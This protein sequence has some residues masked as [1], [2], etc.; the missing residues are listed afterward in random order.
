MEEQLM[1]WHFNCQAERSP[2]DEPHVNL[3]V[4]V[5]KAK[6][7]RGLE[8]FW[9]KEYTAWTCSTRGKL[10]FPPRPW[11]CDCQQAFFAAEA[12]AGEGKVVLQLRDRDCVITAFD[13]LLGRRF[14][15]AVLAMVAT[16]NAEKSSAK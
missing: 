6:A 2:V 13:V 15:T 9:G 11:Q 8:Y 4:S 12:K 14:A 5:S 1:T 16:H 10:G 7:L 3:E